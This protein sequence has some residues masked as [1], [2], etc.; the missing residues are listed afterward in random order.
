MIS[1]MK[2][3]EEISINDILQF[4]KD[5]WFYKLNDIFKDKQDN[6][7][8]MFHGFC[9]KGRKNLKK[10]FVNDYGKFQIQEE[11]TYEL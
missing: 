6:E 2:S 11:V 7:Y 1:I 8:F 4:K 9:I 3:V 10:H 5:K